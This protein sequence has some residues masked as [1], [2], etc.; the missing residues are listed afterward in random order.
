M[1]LKRHPTASLSRFRIFPLRP[2]PGSGNSGTRVPMALL[3]ASPTAANGAAIDPDSL[4]T[5]GSNL[6]PASAL[7]NDGTPFNVPRGHAYDVDGVADRIARAPLA[8]G[9]DWHSCDLSV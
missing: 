5:G 4:G 3:T 1:P 2:L 9:S 6:R 8:N 7:S